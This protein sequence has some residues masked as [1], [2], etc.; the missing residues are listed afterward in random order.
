MRYDIRSADWGGFVDVMGEKGG[1]GGGWCMLWRQSRPAMTAG[2]GEGNRLAMKALFDGGKVPGLIAWHAG[3]AV[4][5]VQIDAR[6]AFPRLAT[7]RVLLPVDDQPVWSVSC[8]LVQKPHRRT[9]LSVALLRA[10]CD[11][12]KSQGARLIEG[13]PIHTPKK[14]YTPVYAWTGFMGT[15]RAAGFIEVARRSETR[16]IMRKDLD[17]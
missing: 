9:G 8:F 17:A 13:Y 2:M 7:S 4:G 6:T 12:A 3:R 15:F 14:D 1:C 16:P 11:F 10:A 5:W